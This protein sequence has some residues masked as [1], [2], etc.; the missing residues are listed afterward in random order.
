MGFQQKIGIWIQTG[1]PVQLRHEPSSVV[2]VIT[3]PVKIFKDTDDGS[4]QFI[5][6]RDAAFACSS[7]LGIADA[8]AL[9][10]GLLANYRWGELKLDKFI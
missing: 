7:A 9:A 10:A 2:R 4:I 5:Q 6:H 8:D 3:R 1:Q